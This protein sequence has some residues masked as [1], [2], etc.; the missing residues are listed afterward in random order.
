M[1]TQYS[2]LSSINNAIEDSRS[3]KVVK[4]VISL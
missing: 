2:T 1:I 3:A 4:A